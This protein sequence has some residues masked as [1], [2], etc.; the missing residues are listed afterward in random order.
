MRYARHGRQQKSA[1]WRGSQLEKAADAWTEEHS[2]AAPEGFRNNRTHD[3]KHAFD[4]EL[5]A[6]GVLFEDRQDMLGH[7]VVASRRAA[8]KHKL[9]NLIEAANR[10]CKTEFRK[11]PATTWLRRKV[12]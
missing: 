10:V 2:E 1:I 6:A 8:P 4:R 9:T 3:L 11:T 7:R 12:E 5:C